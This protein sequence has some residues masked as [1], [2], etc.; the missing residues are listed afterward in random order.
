[1]ASETDQ[2]SP[3]ASPA[4]KKTGVKRVNNVPLGIGITIVLLFMALIAMTAIKRGQE[5]NQQEEALP[6]GSSSSSSKMANDIVGGRL[7]GLIE[8]TLP[9][10]PLLPAEGTEAQEQAAS[11]VPVARVQNPDAPPMPPRNGGMDNSHIE[12]PEAEQLRQAKMQAFQAAVEAKT[13]ITLPDMSG[14]GESTTSDQP[15]QTR[16]E[17]LD[18]IAQVRREI[19]Q[20]R[21]TDPN[22]AY[23]RALRHAQA[24]NGGAG[25]SSGSRSGSAG[26]SLAAGSGDRGA[27]YSDFDN[28]GSENRWKLNSKMEA[29]TTPYE[30]R[31]GAVIP[32]IM[33]SGINS[34]LPGQIMAQVSQDV[35]DTAT[36]KYLLI[37]QGTRMVGS[38]SS[39]IGFGQE[40]VLIAWQRL[41]FP[42]GKALDIGSM[43]G[44]DMAG[45]SGFRDKVNRHLL[46]IYGSA[47]FMTG[48]TA[49]A[50]MATNQ[51][52]N[53]TGG[54]EQPSVN[55]EL[56]AA[57]GQQ[58]GQVS[59][60][61]IEK[62]LNVAP[63]IEIR[64][65]YRFNIVT[66]KDVAFTKSYQSFDY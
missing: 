29:P 44:A 25:A 19:D 3:D 55:S 34:D 63:T 7:N 39:D 50:S 60:Q 37:P 31:A 40:G 61:I 21:V 33:L 26:M 8:Q 57:L 23:Q 17:M 64:P 20:Q 48:I 42:D 54:Y 45:Y 12:D 35:Y 56:S 65:G 38:Y 10:P 62:N 51:N 36:G 28:N 52:S 53:N 59:A 13:T 1:M 41:V 9:E 22:A 5:A 24:V 66:V 18:R 27:D 43:P 32:G 16:G 15:P 14:I 2:L 46:R 47:L 11:G 6:T 30:L 4:G 58:L 49:G